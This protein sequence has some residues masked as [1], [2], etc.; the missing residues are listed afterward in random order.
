[1]SQQNGEKLERTRTGVAEVL[2]LSKMGFVQAEQLCTLSVDRCSCLL[3]TVQLPGVSLA[4]VE[5]SLTFLE[6]FGSDTQTD[7]YTAVFVELL[8]QL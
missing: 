6:N 7:R 8:P 4:S 2:K 1:M 5:V 3:S